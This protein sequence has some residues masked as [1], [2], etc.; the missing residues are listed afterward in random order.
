MQ[1]SARR[2]GADQGGLDARRVQPS[3]GG[4]GG[5]GEAFVMANQRAVDVGNEKPDGWHVVCSLARSFI[6]PVF[7]PDVTWGKS[8]IPEVRDQLDKRRLVENRPLFHILAPPSP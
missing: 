7:D 4:N 6:L 8:R 3:E 5:I 1:N 2:P